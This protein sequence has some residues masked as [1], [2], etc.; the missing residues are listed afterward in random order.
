MRV[1]VTSDY[2]FIT[3]ADRAVWTDGP[4]HYD[5]WRRLLSAFDEVNVLAR[6]TYAEQ[7]QPTW[8]RADGNG[9]GFSPLPN[10][11]GPCQYARRALRIRRAAAAA[12]RQDDAVILNVPGQIG[13][14]LRA[15]LPAGRPYAVQV[16]GDPYDVF[17]PGVL[18]H[19]LR[20]LLRTWCTR[21]LRRH[22]AGAVAALY[23]T[24]QSLQTHYPCPALMTGVSDVDLTAEAFRDVEPATFELEPGRPLRIVS[25]GTMSQ[26]YKGFD[27]LIEALARA[28]SHTVR[29]KIP[30]DFHLTLVGDGKFRPQLEQLVD[31]LG[32]RERVTFRGQ[33]AAGPQVRAE[34]DAADLFVL[35]SRTEGLPRALVEAMARGLPSLAS[36]VGGIPELLADE[37]LLPAGDVA[38]WSAALIS[39]SADPARRAAMARRNVAK[40]ADY[41]AEVLSARRTDFY[42][43][44]ARATAAHCHSA[45][46]ETSRRSIAPSS[47]STVWQEAS[48]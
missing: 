7:P 1:S 2:R 34:L 14:C 4:C 47:S 26:L 15:A 36:R 46:I 28:V 44:V 22:A 21:Q 11:L 23:V 38:A 9:V 24:Q 20:P 25:V 41:R 27:V 35:P 10:Y 32:I 18:R 40:A 19:P 43:D 48:P 30:G 39:M 6:M 13:T 29:W 42:R 12:V 5:V 45:R 37:D 33:L 16:V 8:R 3:T 17:A 31:R